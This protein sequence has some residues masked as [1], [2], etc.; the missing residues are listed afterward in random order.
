MV[1][2]DIQ[3]ASGLRRFHE[4]GRH[5]AS[6]TLRCVAASVMVLSLVVAVQATAVA[7]SQRFPDVPPDHYAF[8]AVE[9]AAE[10]GVTTG[11]T[12]GTFKPER[13]LSKR[14][15]VV[16][17]ERYYDGILGAEE[18]EDFTRG[19]MMVILKAIN[20]GNIRD[21]DSD[22]AAGS[23]SEEGASQ[24]FPD[25]PPDYYAFEAVEWAAEVGVTT[26][27]T[28]GTFKPERPLIKRHAVVFME[29]Y[30]D[31]ILGAEESEDFTR[32]DMMVI[33]K[34][35]NDGNITDGAATSESTPPGEATAPL[36][37]Y[38]AV[39]SGAGHSCAVRT[40]GILVCEG[41]YFDHET[42]QIMED[43]EIPEG[44]FSSIAAGWN[45]AC[46]MYTDGTAECWGA[47]THGQARP[48]RARIQF[49]AIDAGNL[50][51]CAVGLDR[52]VTCWGANTYG[53][54]KS[55]ARGG[56]V[57]I[58]A[59][60]WHTCGVLSD[61]SISCW[62]DNFYGQAD[63]PT[64][65]SFSHVAAGAAHSCG[66]GTDGTI[67][68]WGTSNIGIYVDQTVAPEGTFTAISDGAWH[69]CAI[70][71]DGTIVCWGYRQDVED[72]TARTSIP[73][74]TYTAVSAGW[75]VT[76]AINNRGEVVCFW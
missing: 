5:R 75:N 61:G 19:D 6:S 67:S 42:G 74:G 32:G 30:Y 20:D 52:R 76:C 38:T 34:A 62:G 24:R 51:S 9:W 3:R 15:A 44:T 46:G 29:R 53:Q 71:T 64:G 60:I 17:M 69:T 28:D 45:H 41:M 66:L 22:T 63:A 2:R 26:G 37:T 27:Y 54:S 18:S 43:V 4:C 49:S 16:F 7:Q 55:P 36:D 14:H 50:H 25:V 35:I 58:D 8:E 68:C 56:F 11:Y 72:A 47:N 59:G 70:R 12:D 13:P 39:A 57:A 48:P 1:V 31:G 40:D 65:G 21:T 33:L 73:D 10:V 23:P